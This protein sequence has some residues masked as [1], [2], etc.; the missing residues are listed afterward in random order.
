MAVKRPRVRDSD[1]EVMLESSQYS[2]ETDP[3]EERALEQMVVGVSTRKY[4]RSLEDVPSSMGPRS[5][6]KSAVSR[7]FV[8]ATKKQLRTCPNTPVA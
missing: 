3:L 1:G 6:S 7:R 8:A 2:S 5:A 4:Q